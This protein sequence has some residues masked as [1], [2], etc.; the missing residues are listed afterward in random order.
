MPQ[1]FFHHFHTAHHHYE[2][3]NQLFYM[4]SLRA[5][6]SSLVSV[7]IPIYFLHIYNNDIEAAL[8]VIA[9]YYI[10]I[11][12]LRALLNPL[13]AVL[14]SRLGAKHVLTISAGVSALSTL[15]LAYLDQYYNLL[16][17]IVLLSGLNQ[18]LFF[19]ALHTDMSLSTKHRKGKQVSAIEIA[20]KLVMAIGPLVGGLIAGTVG[21]YYGFIAATVILLVST[22]GLKLSDEPTRTKHPFSWRDYKEVQWKAHLLANVGMGMNLVSAVLLWPLFVY[23]LVGSYEEVG[24]VVSISLALSIFIMRFLGVHDSSRS[25][26]KQINLGSSFTALTHVIRPITSTFGAITGVNLANDIAYSTLVVPYMSSY[27]KN[28]DQTNRIAYVSL[29]EM[30][31]GLGAALTFGLVLLLA[32]LVS[33]QVA[34]VSGFIIGAF[35]SLAAQLIKK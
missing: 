14:V 31:F 27:Y 19:T 23:L 32:L 16:L 11:Y 30:A 13:G 26:R 1:F 3:Y 5:L 18:A 20:R 15:C 7:F 2:E 10:G 24:V 4:R 8:P 35:G 12:L 21:I 17:L 6:A 25:T 34:I 9:M 29:M 28:A 22:F 33:A